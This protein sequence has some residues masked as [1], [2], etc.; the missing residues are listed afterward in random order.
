MGSIILS[1]VC[2]IR[3]K[4]GS[5][6]VKRV[7]RLSE[8][9][10]IDM[11]AF[12]QRFIEENKLDLDRI[13]DDQI[14]LDDIEL[15]KI[16][17]ID[18]SNLKVAFEIIPF[19]P[20]SED[21]KKVTNA[22]IKT[23][24]N[25]LFDQE[26]KEKISYETKSAFL[27]QFS[28]L[29]LKSDRSDIDQYFQ[30]FLEKFDASEIFSDLLSEII[31]AQDNLQKHDQFWYIWDDLLYSKMI[32]AYTEE[33]NCQ[34]KKDVI[35][36][37]LFAKAP[38]TQ[39]IKE[40]HSIKEGNKRFF[41]LISENIGH[42]PT[43][44]YSLVKLLN[45]VGSI[46]LKDGLSWISNILENNENL[47]TDELDSDTI[48]YMEILMRKYIFMY[49]D[50]IKKTMKLKSEALIILEYMIKRGS[51]SAYMWREMIY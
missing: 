5:I 12:M 29:V 2:F 51:A 38:W 28:Y 39:N 23:F 43:V 9:Y 15:S 18:P 48:F 7:E 31:Y 19:V 1:E 47:L 8:I 4:S 20:E 27:K 46:Y 6:K 25:H 17:H 33:F 35:K 3:E 44:L 26:R 14:K 32:K 11:K 42:C 24:A 34:Y 37:Y 49:H 13:V 40:W 41:K 16:E 22:I 30:P 36:S 10:T 21:R 45:G 50:E